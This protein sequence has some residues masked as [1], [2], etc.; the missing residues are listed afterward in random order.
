MLIVIHDMHRS[1]S[2]LYQ[3]FFSG[4]NFWRLPACIAFHLYYE[5]SNEAELEFEFLENDTS[6]NAYVY[7][8]TVFV[9]WGF[10]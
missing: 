4:K 7:N 1:V 5:A 10:N 8:K 9:R 3:G 6:Y 2:C